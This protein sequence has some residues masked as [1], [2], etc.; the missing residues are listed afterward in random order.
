MTE[1]INKKRQEQFLDIIN[2]AKKPLT[3]NIGIAGPRFL[4]EQQ[5]KDGLFQLSNIMHNIANEIAL[6]I[7]QSDVAKQLYQIERNKQATIRLTSSLAIGADRLSMHEDLAK[8]CKGLINVEYAAILPFNFENRQ[9]G[10][11]ETQRT[12]KE[13]EN[14]LQTLN[15]F[16]DQIKQ[17]DNFHLIEL[18]GDPSTLKTLDQAHYQ[19]TE[20]LI[21]NIDLLIAITKETNAPQISSHQAGTNTTVRLA[22]EAEL[23]VIQIAFKEKCKESSLTIHPTHTSSCDP[24]AA[25]YPTTELKSI[26]SSLILFDDI[27]RVE[28]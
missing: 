23:P 24:N 10:F 28:K 15:E 21:G 5:Y 14:D 4:S 27:S 1:K 22:K 17:Q 6:I 11:N 12:K 13:N 9:Q 19:C 8:A 25:F 16:I 26:L 7:E 3:L 2:N 18:N 20:S